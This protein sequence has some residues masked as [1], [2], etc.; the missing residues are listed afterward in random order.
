MAT[1]MVFKLLRRNIGFEELQIQMYS[2]LKPSMAFQLMHIENGYFLVK[3]QNSE[4]YVKVLSQGPW[5]IFGQYRMV[6]PWIMD[7]NPAKPY[8]S[9]VMTWI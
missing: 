2:L 8:P 7:F 3:S 9:I 6:Q 5:T 4:D 1:S